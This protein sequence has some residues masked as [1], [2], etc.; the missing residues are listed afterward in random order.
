M[1]VRELL[2]VLDLTNISHVK[3]NSEIL[4]LKRLEKMEEQI[5]T[6]LKIRAENSKLEV[7]DIAY[8]G[9]DV[10]FY[11]PENAFYTLIYIELVTKGN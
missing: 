6:H 1:T 9:D 11:L 8:D 5:I 2:N 7:Y 10:N 3:V 4:T